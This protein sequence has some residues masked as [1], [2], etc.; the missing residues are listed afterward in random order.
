MKDKMITFFAT[1]G[2]VGFFPKAPGT[3]GSF[4]ALLLAMPFFLLFRQPNYYLFIV[5]LTFLTIIGFGVSEAYSNRTGIEDPKEV[6]IDELIGQWLVLAFITPKI[7]WHWLLAFAL[8]RL[9]DIIK[10]FPVDYFDK[11]VKGGIGIMLDDIVAGIMA[12]LT[13]LLCIWALG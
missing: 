7:W 4:V 3:I 1:L 5:A 6:V 2:Y 10:P 8:F 11:K 13:F 9:F 12:A